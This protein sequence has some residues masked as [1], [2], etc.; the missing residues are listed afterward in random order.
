MFFGKYRNHKT[1]FKVN[2]VQTC[3]RKIKILPTIF[4]TLVFNALTKP[5]S[6]V[7]KIYYS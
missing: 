1:N 6:K 3:P 2:L 7:E 4:N 5:I